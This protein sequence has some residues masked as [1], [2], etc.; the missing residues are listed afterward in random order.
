MNRFLIIL[1]FIFSNFLF[2]NVSLPYF[3]GDNMVLQRNAEV[4][5]WG[6]ASKGEKIT[7]LFK[8]QK[9][10]T[11]ADIDGNWMVKI[12]PE[13]EGGPFS[14]TVSGQNT[15]VFKNILIGD[16]WLCSGQSNMEWAMRDSDGYDEE[17]KSQNF[18]QVRQIKFQHDVN[19]MPQENIKEA[20]W[21]PADQRN[22]GDFSGVAYFFAKKM[23]AE[24]GVP[25]GILN[26]N[27]GGTNI[28]TWIPREAFEK[29]PQ[30]REMILKMPK[31]STEQLLELS[32]ASNYHHFSDLQKI[33]IGSFSESEVLKNG[34]NKISAE[35]FAPKSWEEQGYAGLDG[36]VWLLKSVELSKNEISGDA[37]LNLNQIDDD[38]VTYFNGIEIGKTS[39]WAEPRTYK[40]PKE[41]LKIGQNIIAVK[42]DDNGGNGGIWGEKDNL[43]IVTSSGTKL[44]AGPWKFYI[45]NLLKNL[46]QNEYPSIVYNA[47]VAP[48]APFSVKGILWYQGESNAER[49]EEYNVSFPL[50]IDAWREKFGQNLPFYFVQLSTFT[51]PGNSNE[52]CGW[53]EIREAQS[54]TLSIKNTG[55]AVIIDIGNPGNIHPKN[56]KDVGYRLANL[57][58]DN[59]KISPVMK[60]FK[61]IGNKIT[62]S[63]KPEKSLMIK[64][65]D[66]EL[67]GFEIAGAD[68]KFYPAKAKIIGKTVEIWFENVTKPVAARYGWLGDDSKINLF[69]TE[70]LPVSPFRTDQFKSPFSGR[71]YALPEALKSIQK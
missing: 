55:M 62:V 48:L 64:R 24:T 12:A 19:T 27:W 7:V 26:V 41:L 68:Q 8:N 58:L 35:I 1:A 43:K 46:N 20:H 69:T 70:G 57:A 50:L 17:L 56:K 23:F 5:I 30:F 18:P 13:K 67:Q 16:V 66:T 33:K 36:T 38:D 32:Q 45:Q 31:V 42:V 21:I 71:K 61:I 37:I 49:P 2:G 10:Q 59:G 11:T 54:R 9:K 63:F 47:M 22:L 4:P 51:Q 25:Q 60:D 65:G 34:F 6:K 29:S 52:G 14:L 3:F 28:E 53:C 44:L 15:L 40:I 39:G